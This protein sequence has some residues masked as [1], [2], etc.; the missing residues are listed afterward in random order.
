MDK[1]QAKKMAEDAENKIREGLG[2]IGEKIESI[3][4]DELKASAEKLADEAA[5]LVR[6]YP[7]QTAGVALAVGFVLGA[8]FSR[9][10]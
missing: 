7:L 9:R 5:T 1:S 2:A 10:N 6:K 3:D 4:T 8:L